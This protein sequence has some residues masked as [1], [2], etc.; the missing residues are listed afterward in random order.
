MKKC[1]KCCETKELTEFSKN[2]SRCDGLSVYCKPCMNVYFNNIRNRPKII[3]ETKVCRTCNQTKEASS[4]S[5][6]PKSSDGLYHE[7]K[8]CV[9]VNNKKRLL[10][11]KEPPAQKTCVCCGETKD[12]SEFTNKKYR[13]DGKDNTCK[14]C[15]VKNYRTYAR[16][17]KEKVN[18]ASRKRYESDINYKLCEILRSRVRKAIQNDQ[19]TGS[20][21]KDLGCSVDELKKHLES[22][23]EDGM[24]WD[25]WS[26]KGWHIDHIIPLSAFDLTERDQFLKACH[27]TN[28]QPLWAEDNMQKK[29][30]LDW[31]K[32]IDST[33]PKD[34]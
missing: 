21:V 15:N 11:K 1:P 13:S 25:N 16:T 7:C 34:V 31:V 20:A 14:P 28:L 2:K 18:T 5:T 32:P 29:A 9:S 17:N 6:H 27:Y 30:K 12:I 26:P 22:K 3:P 33:Q 24:S 19:K 8:G 4:F 10:K 23:F